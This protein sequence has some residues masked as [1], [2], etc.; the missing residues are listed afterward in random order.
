MK[1]KKEGIEF[2]Y[3]GDIITRRW[4]FFFK[5]GSKFHSK[6]YSMYFNSLDTYWN[7][8]G[9][10]QQAFAQRNR[11]KIEGFSYFDIITSW[12]QSAYP[13]ENVVVLKDVNVGERGLSFWARVPKDK[14]EHI[15]KDV[16]VLICGSKENAVEI[17]DSIEPS[18][19]EAYAFSGGHLI[20]YN[21]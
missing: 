8:V 18:F 9:K 7:Y 11:N 4:P 12:I 1:L 6:N 3:H 20:N 16:I 5:E 17:V 15:K 21:T 14:I 19:A 13:D 2:D 10:V